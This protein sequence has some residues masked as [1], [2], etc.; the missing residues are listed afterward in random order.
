MQNDFGYS[1]VFYA[2]YSKNRYCTDDRISKIHLRKKNYT[3]NS[4]C[5]SSF[6]LKLQRIS[7][8][9]K[10]REN[11][12]PPCRTCLLPP[13]LAIMLGAGALHQLAFFPAP[14]L[15]SF[16]PPSLEHCSLWEEAWETD[17]ITLRSAV[18]NF[19]VLYSTYYALPNARALIRRYRQYW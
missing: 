12:G 11:A 7:Q 2:M 9:K 16:A 4:T 14:A 1:K 18:S 15:T 3:L 6:Y 17:G 8:K 19:S 13:S 10:T 5:R